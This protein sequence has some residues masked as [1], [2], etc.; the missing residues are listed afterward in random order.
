MNLRVPWGSRDIVVS[1]ALVLAAVLIMAP[2]GVFFKDAGGFYIGTLGLASVGIFGFLMVGMSVYLGPVRYGLPLTRLGLRSRVNTQQALLAVGVLLASLSFN[3]AYVLVLKVA[4]WENMMPTDVVAELGLQ[5][6][7]YVVGA[8]LIVLWG[9]FSEEIFFRAFIFT[10]LAS[11]FGWLGAAIISAALFA[12]FHGEYGV[13]IPAFFTGL[14][15]AGLY[16]WTGSLWP[17]LLAHAT[18]N[19]AALF[20]SSL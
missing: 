9:P 19:A 13:M 16:W 20:T 8:F 11:R 14:L 1:I 4:G 18:Q 3:L 6:A 10:G 5:G 17:C 12:A 2:V 7:E 15:L